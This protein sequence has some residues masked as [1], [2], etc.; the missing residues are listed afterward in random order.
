MENDEQAPR[1]ARPILEST[2]RV[3]EAVISKIL[4]I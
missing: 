3:N 1:D 4:G 2:I